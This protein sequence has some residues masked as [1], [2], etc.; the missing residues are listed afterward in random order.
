MMSDDLDQMIATGLRA[1]S[2]SVPDAGFSR[3]VQKEVS[4]IRARRKLARLLPGLFAVFGA[5]LV[6]LFQVR[7]SSLPGILFGIVG[8]MAHH[9][10]TP[11]HKLPLRVSR[12]RVV[13]TVG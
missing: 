10:D 5:T 7:W 1:Q 2:Q 11:L 8:R 6:L 12:G 3:T 4:R 9:T 13:Q